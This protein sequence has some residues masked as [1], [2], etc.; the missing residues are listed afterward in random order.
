MVPNDVFVKAMGIPAQTG[1]LENVKAAEGHPPAVMV[2]EIKGMESVLGGEAFTK[3][4]ME[5]SSR[6]RINDLYFI[7]ICL[8]SP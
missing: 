4:L 6:K 3:P 7:E 2:L 8:K 1:V 5:H